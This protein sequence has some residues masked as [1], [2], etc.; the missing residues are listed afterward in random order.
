MREITLLK[1]DRF[2]KVNAHVLFNNKKSLALKKSSSDEQT[3]NQGEGCGVCKLGS[4]W[5]KFHPAQ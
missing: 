4:R 2:H 3:A 5:S 1:K